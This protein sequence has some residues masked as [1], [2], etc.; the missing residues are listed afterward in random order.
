MT[1]A[2]VNAQQATRAPAAVQMVRV[3]V[4]TVTPLTVTLPGGGTV[5]GVPVPGASYVVGAAAVALIQEPAV[6]PIFPL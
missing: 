3:T 2:R 4:A 1:R 5:A 6:G